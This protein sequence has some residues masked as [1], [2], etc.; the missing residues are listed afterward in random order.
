M[1]SVLRSSNFS[2]NT[3]LPPW[4]VRKIGWPARIMAS[5][6][7]SYISLIQYALWDCMESQC[8]VCGS[9]FGTKKCYFCQRSICS[10]C[11]VPTDV[12]GNYTTTKCITCDQRKI[13]KISVLSVLNRNKFILGVLGGF[14]I[15]TVFPLPFLQMF[16]IKIDP[17]S[18]QPIFIATA[19][20]TIPF[21]FMLFAWQKRSPNSSASTQVE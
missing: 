18:F 8:N 12:T 20:M 10:S 9:K 3:G 7:S 15:Y 13:N 11:I 1:R 19:V 17:T 2:T 14:W 16:G 5:A 21:V 6:K 4:Y